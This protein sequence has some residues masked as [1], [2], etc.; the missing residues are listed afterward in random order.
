[1]TDRVI[2]TVHDY[3]QLVGAL[4]ARVAELGV[5]YETVDHVSGLSNTHTSKLLALVPVKRLGRTSLGL[6]LGALGLKI[7]VVED[8]E[9]LRLVAAR[10]KRKE[11]Q[12]ASSGM[13]PH[14][15][16]ANT[17]NSLWSKVL[18]SRRAFKL[19]PKQRTR[20]AKRAA[21]ARWRKRTGS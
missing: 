8:A 11:D 12:Y 4:R 6:V 2:A 14:K 18:N 5:S 17:G 7:I 13:H 19:T 9:A 1:M 21:M 20:I 10:L 15:K 16:R 3:G